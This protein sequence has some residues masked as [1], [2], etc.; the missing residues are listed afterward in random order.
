MP[1]AIDTMAACLDSAGMGQ[2]AVHTYRREQVL[3]LN[4]VDPDAAQ[5]IIDQLDAKMAEMQ[6]PLI[7]KA[8]IEQT[9]DPLS[10][11]RLHLLNGEL[12]AA[13]P[14]LRGIVEKSSRRSDKYERALRLIQ[15]AMALHD[16]HMHDADRYERDPYNQQ[17]A[18]TG[19]AMV[20][21]LDQLPPKQTASTASK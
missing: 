1:D 12:V 4:S 13:V 14:T 3:G 10:Q 6:Q 16:G 7:D 17:N 20:N 8:I 15:M 2:D 11:A 21:P 19:D 9:E 5:A 18:Q